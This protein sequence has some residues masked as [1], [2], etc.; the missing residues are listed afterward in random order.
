MSEAAFIGFAAIAKKARAAV[1]G[2]GKAC[3]RA[4][5]WLPDQAVKDM[6]RL[7]HELNTSSSS[8]A[9]PNDICKEFEKRY[10]YIKE[11]LTES[12]MSNSQKDSLA[13][14]LAL[15]N[16]TLGSFVSK[17]QWDTLYDRPVKQPI[18]NNIMT[19]AT[20]NFSQANATYISQSIIEVAYGIGFNNEKVNRYKNGIQFLTL[21]DKDGRALIAKIA[22]SNQGAKINLDLT[23]FE[24]KSCHKVMDSILNGLK[25]KHIQLEQLQLHSHYCH[26]GAISK[27]RSISQKN[28]RKDKQALLDGARRRKIHHAI[29]PLKFRKHVNNL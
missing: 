24:D 28:D 3:Y 7:E 11:K 27:R 20:K 22:E 18:F 9:V 2:T 5:T 4:V 21:I 16:S 12:P 1:M 23:G 6:E 17:S 15:R 19:Q 13:R 8:N 25:R 26:E 10:A 14:L 29:A